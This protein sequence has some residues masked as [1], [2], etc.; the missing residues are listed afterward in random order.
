M[1]I[2]SKISRESQLEFLSSFGKKF[3]WKILEV[4][5]KKLELEFQRA[6]EKQ[7]I[8]SNADNRGS[9]IEFVY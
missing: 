7:L 1:E 2:F 9:R 5:C 8:E 3:L 4:T 6:L